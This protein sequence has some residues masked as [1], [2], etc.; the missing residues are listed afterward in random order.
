MRKYPR[1]WFAVVL[2]VAG[3]AGC[4]DPSRCDAVEANLARV[5]AEAAQ[6]DAQVAWILYQQ[7]VL[8]ERVD[9]Q[10]IDGRD[11]LIRMIA[12]LKTENA[13]LA[14]RLDRA[15]R[16]LGLPAAQPRALDDGVPFVQAIAH[17]HP[18]DTAPPR[19]LDERVPY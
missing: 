6:R 2:A 1:L 7:R 14:E 5:R 12:A 4:A 13:V 9:V 17:P 19:T 3:A 10:G 16:R 18:R 15:E 11:A 8:S